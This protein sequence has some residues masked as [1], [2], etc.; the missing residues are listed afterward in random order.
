MDI[1]NILREQERE[2]NDGITRL[3]AEIE[4]LAARKA[5]V[6]AA[7]SAV[8]KMRTAADLPTQSV[9]TP[10]QTEANRMPIDDAIIEA[11]KNDARAP[12][13]ILSFMQKHLGVQTTINSVRTRVS[14]LRANGRL[15]H[16]QRGWVLPEQI[17][18]GLPL[19]ENDP[20]EGGSDA[21]EVTASSESPTQRPQDAQPKEGDD[22]LANQPVLTG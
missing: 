11:V 19:N 10:R 17:H 21:E 22:G 13:A 5:E 7:I 15:T 2:V 8:L 20:P 3:E 4:S 16:D 12:A 6:Q 9:A 1:L 14:R 18:E